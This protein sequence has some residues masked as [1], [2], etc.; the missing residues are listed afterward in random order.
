MNTDAIKCLTCMKILNL[1]VFLPCGHTICKH[2]VDKA[3]ENNETNIKCS[4]CDK[5]IHIPQ[6][7]FVGNRVLENLLDEMRKSSFG[8]KFKSDYN[9][10]V[11]T[12]DSFEELL[13]E[14]SRIKN[15]PEMKI[16]TVISELRNKV[17]LKREEIKNE[18]DRKAL[19]LIERIDEFEKE[20]K[21]NSSNVKSDCKLEETLDR[22][23]NDLNETKKS[24]VT[25]EL[26]EKWLNIVDES[27]SAIKEI[28]SELLEFNE[29]LFLNRLNS[30][31]CMNL[32]VL[33]VHFPIR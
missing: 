25:F 19:T 29:S 33:N 12:S 15:D 7:G 21:A 10:A 8:E 14:L 3:I 9:L 2:H 5:F 27:K 20:C 31:D 13:E 1:P 22:L 11:K 28:R 6:D 30:F 32:S 16:N 4:I 17:D 26:V 24:S 18:I 23:K